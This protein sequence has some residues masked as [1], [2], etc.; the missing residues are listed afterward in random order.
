MSYSF[1][2]FINSWPRNNIANC[3]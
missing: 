2:K 1:Q 3:R